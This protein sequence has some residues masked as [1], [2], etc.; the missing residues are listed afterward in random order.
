MTLQNQFLKILLFV[1]LPLI[2]WS[3]SC[4]ERDYYGFDAVPKTNNRKPF[5]V[6]ATEAYTIRSSSNT[7][8]LKPTDTLRSGNRIYIVDREQGF[9]IYDTLQT[10]LGAVRAD[11][12]RL[13]ERP[14]RATVSSGHKICR[15]RRESTAEQR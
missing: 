14:R 9:F 4:V 5:Y 10:L 1:G 3:F 12:G 2:L 13:L 8:A 7:A 15:R 6:S 11:P